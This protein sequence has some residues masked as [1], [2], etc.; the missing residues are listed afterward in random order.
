MNTNCYNY[1]AMVAVDITIDATAF[2]ALLLFPF[3]KFQ[4][5]YEIRMPFANAMLSLVDVGFRCL[6][7][8]Q[9]NIKD[10]YK[11]N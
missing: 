4:R 7:I 5:F 6:V 1:A 2:F 3:S 10:T 11:I 9:L 8:I